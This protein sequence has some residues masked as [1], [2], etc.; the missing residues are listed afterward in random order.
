MTSKNKKKIKN[1]G[2]KIFGYAMLVLAVASALTSIL[3]YA[4]N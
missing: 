1:I 3:V 2:K 4:F